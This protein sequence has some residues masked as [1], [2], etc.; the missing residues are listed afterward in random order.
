MLEVVD[1]QDTDLHGVPWGAILVG[2]TNLQSR[3]G[4]HPENQQGDVTVA[5]WT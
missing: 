3:L 5:P 2:N 1:T 4:I